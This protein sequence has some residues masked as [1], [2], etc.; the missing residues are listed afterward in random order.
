MQA[1]H[2][3][4]LCPS[5]RCVPSHRLSGCRLI[6]APW[7]RPPSQHEYARIESHA[8]SDQHRGPLGRIASQAVAKEDS[9]RTTAQDFAC[10]VCYIQFPCKR[11]RGTGLATWTPT[12]IFPVG[13]FPLRCR[14]M[15]PTNSEQREQRHASLIKSLTKLANSLPRAFEDLAELYP[16]SRAQ[17]A[18]VAFDISKLLVWHIAAGH[19][20]LHESANALQLCSRRLLNASEPSESMAT[21]ACAMRARLE[22]LEAIV[23]EQETA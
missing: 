21:A 19:P 15:T 5:S 7:H 11:H 6:R 12:G 17:L 4:C 3:R 1:P 2:P 14:L 9:R 13:V 20:D 8:V 18:W 10:A 22:H 16:S 23:K